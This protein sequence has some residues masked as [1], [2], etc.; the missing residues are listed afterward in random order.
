MHKTLLALNIVLY[1]SGHCFLGVGVLCYIHLE[2]VKHHPTSKS[3]YV[4]NF[5]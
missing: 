5:F 1:G 3:L 4:L 2:K